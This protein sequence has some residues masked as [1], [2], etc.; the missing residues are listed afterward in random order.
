MQRPPSK[1]GKQSSNMQ[2]SHHVIPGEARQRL[3]AR[4]Q[5]PGSTSLSKV[6]P[7]SRDPG[8]R[9]NRLAGMTAQ[10]LPT[11]QRTVAFLQRTE[12]LRRRNGRKRLVEIAGVLGLLG[13]LHLEQI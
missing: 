4:A 10:Y 1:S 12:G 9:R 6:G 3:R 2:S 7:G 13:L 8:S 5:K 11:D